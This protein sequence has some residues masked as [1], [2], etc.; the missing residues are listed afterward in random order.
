M[1]QGNASRYHVLAVHLHHT[2]SSNTLATPYTLVMHHRTSFVVHADAA[3]QA[4][5]P[6]PQKLPGTSA[7]GREIKSAPVPAADRLPPSSAANHQQHKQA[8]S[9][10]SSTR[11]Q[12]PAHA[13]AAATPAAAAEAG[14]EAKGMFTAQLACKQFLHLSMWRYS[15][16][17][18]C[19][20]LSCRESGCKQ[21]CCE[22]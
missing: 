13:A 21:K 15:V 4:G 11:A 10:P 16:E 1:L 3:E 14:A 12:M 18:A 7:V 17:I 19:W 2:S 5:V 6:E 8:G 22:T 9:A 20:T